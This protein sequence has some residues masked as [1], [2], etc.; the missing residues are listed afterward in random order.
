MGRASKPARQR[1]CLQHAMCWD[2]CLGVTS[3]AASLRHF[4]AGSLK[5]GDDLRGALRA[6]IT[7]TLTTRGGDPALKLPGSDEEGPSVLLIVGVNGGGKTTS[8]G[9]LAHK[10]AAE[11]AKVMLGSGDTFRAAAFE[12]LR[13]WGERTGAAMGSYTEGSRPAKVCVVGDLQPRCL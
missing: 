3:R 11:G 10:F 4:V 8:I 5:T 12:Q 1:S 7:H 9:K 13:T 2:A 6:S